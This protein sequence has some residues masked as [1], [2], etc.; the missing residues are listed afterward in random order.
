MDTVCIQQ[1][2]IMRFY[3]IRT[4]SFP[5]L[6]RGPGFCLGPAYPRPGP[7]FHAQP[8][9]DRLGCVSQKRTLNPDEGRCPTLV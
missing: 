5:T 9:L 1:K 3:A 6:G 2:A 7:K 4:Y 8:I